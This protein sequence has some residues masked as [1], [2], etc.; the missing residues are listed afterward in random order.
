MNDEADELLLLAAAKL[1]RRPATYKQNADHSKHDRQSENVVQCKSNCPG[2]NVV[3][4]VNERA[5]PEI[6]STSL[7][8]TN[9]L[10]RQKMTMV[11][12][13]NVKGLCAA[14]HCCASFGNPYNV[15]C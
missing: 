12:Q 2:D 5:H 1:C 10:Q 4:L 9:C 15:G 14:I 3:C 8:R 11:D 13:L 7:E 6:L